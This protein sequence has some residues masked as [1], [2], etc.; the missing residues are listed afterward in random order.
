[1][2]TCVCV[3]LYVYTRRC[4]FVWICMG[5]CLYVWLCGCVYV[6]VCMRVCLCMYA[7]MSVYVC[8]Y[9]H[10]CAYTHLI[11]RECVDKMGEKAFLV[12]LVKLGPVEVLCF[13]VACSKEERKVSHVTALFLVEK[14]VLDESSAKERKGCVYVR[15]EKRKLRREKRREREKGGEGKEKEKEEG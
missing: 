5:V 15:S 1:M 14:P 12:P 10:A 9:M 2:Y 3:C 13:L 4:V 11:A 6:C 8:M 7:C